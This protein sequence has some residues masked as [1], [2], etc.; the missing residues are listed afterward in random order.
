MR[1]YD[2]EWELY[3]LT[4]DRNELK[5]LS[6][7]NP[8]IVAELSVEWQKLADQ[9]GVIPFRKTLEIYHKQGIRASDSNHHI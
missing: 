7:A 6:S 2:W 3:D 5:D 9:Y 8:Q 1:Q 4:T